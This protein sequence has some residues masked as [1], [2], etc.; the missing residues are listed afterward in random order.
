M[1]A[2]IIN[3]KR[4]R[5]EIGTDRVKISVKVGERIYGYP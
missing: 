2:D 5:V 3:P 1:I 4:A